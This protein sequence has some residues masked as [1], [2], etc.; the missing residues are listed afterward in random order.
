MCHDSADFTNFSTNCVRVWQNHA[1]KRFNRNLLEDS[2][3]GVAKAIEKCEKNIADSNNTGGIRNNKILEELS[4]PEMHDFGTLLMLSDPL[5][6]REAMKTTES[7]SQQ[8]I[9]RMEQELLFPNYDSDK[10]MTSGG[11]KGNITSSKPANLHEAINMARELV[12]QSVQGCEARKVLVSLAFIKAV[13]QKLDEYVVVRGLPLRSPYRLAPSEMLELSNQLKELQEKGFILNKVTPPPP[14]GATRS[15]F[16]RRRLFNENKSVLGLCVT[17]TGIP[18][19]PSKVESVKNWKTPESSTEIRSFLGLAGYYRRF[20]EN[21][22]KIAKPLTLLTQ[23]NKTYVWGDKQDEAFQILKEKL[24]NALVLVSERKTQAKTV[25]A[26]SITIQ[27][28]LKAKIL[29]AREKLPR[30]SK[31]QMNVGGVRNYIWMKL[32]TSRYSVHGCDKMYY[33]L[34]DLYCWPWYDERHCLNRDGRF[35]SHLWQAFQEALGT[36]L[37]MSMAYHPQTDGQSEHTIQTLEDMLRAC[38]MD[39]GGIVK[40]S[41]SID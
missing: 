25:R 3:K 4:V 37:D 31:P 40:N 26:M 21:F 41:S 9:K 27:Y 35:T 8:L 20:I 14:W 38:V 1:A 29:E 7:C 16:V 2:E 18:L 22:S 33:D 19:D 15:S 23:K 13:G 17:V 5:E 36:R 11:I 39:F 10:E 6:Q 24:C 12:E 32:I 28:G 30:I 34:S